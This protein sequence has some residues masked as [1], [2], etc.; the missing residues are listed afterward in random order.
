MGYHTHTL[1]NNTWIVTTSATSELVIQ[2]INAHPI[3]EIVSIQLLAYI[4]EIM[5][6]MNDLMLNIAWK[7]MNVVTK[8]VCN[9]LPHQGTRLKKSKRYKNRTCSSR[10]Q[11]AK[12]NY[13]K[14]L[15]TP[16]TDHPKE[17]LVSNVIQTCSIT[18]DSLTMKK[19]VNDT[20]SDNNTENNTDR[21][22]NN[23][24]SC[25]H[26]HECSPRAYTGKFWS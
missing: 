7:T 24:K 12:S 8:Y 19:T 23:N 16:R 26:T 3:T 25:L 21:N 20:V 6:I 1:L 10:A 15:F 17:T 22:C 18:N 14:H 4:I 11:L 9:C 2:M 5:T 13:K